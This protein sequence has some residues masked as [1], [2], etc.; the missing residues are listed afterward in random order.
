M[1]ADLNGAMTPMMSHD[2][3]AHLL[4]TY[5]YWAIFVI[6]GLESIG[7]PLPGELVVIVAAT[8]ASTQ[9][10]DLAL[11]IA[12]ASAGAIVGDNIGYV[13][14]R[15]FGHR[16]LLRYGSRAGLTPS[17]LKLGQ[18]LFRE[19]GALVV[20]F[21]R[22]VAVLRVLSAFL[23][24]ANLLPWPKF[25]VANALGGVLWATV[26]SVLAYWMGEGLRHL[27]GPLSILLLVAG[28]AGAAAAVGYFK[29]NEERLIAEAERAFPGSIAGFQT[30]GS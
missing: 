26:V 14:G 29:R 1:A 10:G 6:V 22:F 5:G 27:H 24:G 4:N 28:A 2:A 8:F 13:L 18:Y 3:L 9:G 30:S 25:L 7:V 19:Y 15:Q 12:A 23:A 20:F 16:L 17:H 21:G 11:I